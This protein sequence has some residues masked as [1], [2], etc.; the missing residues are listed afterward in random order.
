MQ[1][2]SFLVRVHSNTQS[3]S[4]PLRLRGLEEA[5]T[6]D[7]SIVRNA[8]VESLVFWFSLFILS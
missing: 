2:Y 7:I 4:K 5:K 1:T 8:E 6:S 3:Q